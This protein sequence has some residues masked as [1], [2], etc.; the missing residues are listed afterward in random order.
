[1]E[2]PRIVELKERIVRA[3]SLGNLYIHVSELYHLLQLLGLQPTRGPHFGPSGID[4]DL[5][6][7][8]VPQIS[9]IPP[10]DLPGRDLFFEGMK[11]HFC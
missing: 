5:P 8:F 9:R 7:L 6:R 4:A 10:R 1:M 2:D 11:N 3:K